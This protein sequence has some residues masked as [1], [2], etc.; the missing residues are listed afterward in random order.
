MMN[1]LIAIAAGCASALMFASIISGALFS[2]ALVYLSPLPL[3]VAALGW[4]PASALLGGLI[5]G[6]ILALSFSFMNGLSFV[7]TIAT[8][9]FWLGHVS[10]LAQPASLSQSPGQ[11]DAALEWYPIGRVL[12][13][14][15]TIAA[16]IMIF[17][18][19]TTSGSGGDVTARLREQAL[20]ALNAVN[21]AG[22]AVDEQDKERLATFMARALPLVA[23]GATIVMYVLNLWLAGRITRTSNR[24]RRPWPDLHGAELPRTATVALAVA[25]ALSF[26]GGLLALI[27]QV[28]SAALMTAY[29]LMGLAV[30]HSF[31][32]SS[33]GRLWWRLAAYAAIIM[34]MWPLLLL[35]VVGLIDAS[36]GL[37]RR[38]ANRAGPPPT[39]SS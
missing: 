30:L 37:R 25:L 1:I 8:P 36:F 2:L 17:A 28:V 19:L 6:V 20:E 15:A 13:W 29:M 9:A 23:V 11:Q 39:L 22:V 12:L 32:P 24:L 5:A 31:T 14:A 7:L 33:D 4:G 34:F 35:P 16:L 18:V 27:A 38:F 21:R 26:A 3:M 10:L